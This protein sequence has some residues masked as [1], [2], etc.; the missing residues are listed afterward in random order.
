MKLKELLLLT[1]K[2]KCDGFFIRGNTNCGEYKSYWENGQLSINTFYLKSKRNGEYKYYWT[3]GQLTGHYFYLNDELHGNYKFYQANGQ[4][5]VHQLY[6]NG[7]LIKDY[8]E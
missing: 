2:Q 1:S 6:E 8:L 3:N 5:D 4:L 7:L